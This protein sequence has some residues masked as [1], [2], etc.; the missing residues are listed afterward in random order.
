M[1]KTQNTSTASYLDEAHAYLKGEV[2]NDLPSL[3]Q[4]YILDC[5]VDAALA[6]SYDFSQ[7]PGIYRKCDSVLK[8]LILINRYNGVHPLYPNRDTRKSELYIPIFG[9]F[10]Y[11]SPASDDSMFVKNM[12]A[13]IN[14][15]KAYSE[16]KL[17]ATVASL[18]TR[19]RTACKRFRSY[20]DSLMGTSLLA[21][22]IQTKEQFDSAERI[23]KEQSIY[24]TFGVQEALVEEWPR[25]EEPTWQGA[26]LIQNIFKEPRLS[27][28]LPEKNTPMTLEVFNNKQLIADA[29]KKVIH[30]LLDSDYKDDKKIEAVIEN[31]YTWGSEL[32]LV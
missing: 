21:A 6:V 5:I 9:K 26:L 15:A 2:Y 7:H 1:A 18:R 12:I 20:L 25:E 14:A 29:G 30:H 24:Q 11:E 28:Y 23:L 10:I 4:R 3:Y 31:L 22:G 32:G 8:E 13:T 19:V 27:G 16:N 17:D